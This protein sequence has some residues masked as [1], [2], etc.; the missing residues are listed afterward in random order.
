[1]RSGLGIYL[2]DLDLGTKPL[3]P[4]P[5]KVGTSYEA[6]KTSLGTSSQR[7]LV[8]GSLFRTWMWWAS[9]FQQPCSQKSPSCC[10]RRSATIMFLEG[11]TT[12]S[13]VHQRLPF[14]IA[15]HLQWIA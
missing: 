11:S 7:D 8:W 13:G 2:Q 5:V 4:S 10:S 3:S 12:L 9:P 14:V 1:M 15:D 6:L